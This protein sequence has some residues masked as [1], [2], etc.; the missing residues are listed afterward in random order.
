M[1]AAFLWLGFLLGI[2]HAFEA[3]HLAAVTS[4]ASRSTRLGHTMRVA[5]AWGLG[6]AAVL[7][8]TGT[9][10]VALGAAWPPGVGRALETLAGA[11]LVWLGVDVLR[12]A[13]RAATLHPAVAGAPPLSRALLVG[14]VHGMEG[15]GAVVLLALPAL[16]GYGDAFAY[17]G[18]FGVGSI[19]GMLICSLAVSLPMDAA[20]QRFAGAGRAL[21]LL[22]GATSVLLGGSIAGRALYPYIRSIFT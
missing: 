5:A 22:V 20:A 12:R 19:L 14:G 21:Q 18:V 16:R 11:V 15:S 13:R 7:T 8:A 2:R 6:H 9:L 3:D 1:L 10:M 17:L 4:L